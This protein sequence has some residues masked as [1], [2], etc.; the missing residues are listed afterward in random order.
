[1]SFVVIV[2]LGWLTGC[3]PVVSTTI[4]LYDKGFLYIMNCCKSALT[5]F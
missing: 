2:V 4:V 3:G 5:S 1:M